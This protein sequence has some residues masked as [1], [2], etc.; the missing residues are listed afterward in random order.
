MACPICG[1]KAANCDCTAYER[2]LYEQNE[3]LTEEVERLKAKLK[4]KEVESVGL[5]TNE[6]ETINIQGVVMASQETMDSVA[7][8]AREE[9]KE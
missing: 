5:V 3:E 1:A 2:Q 9:E 7:A 4:S 8:E 6:D